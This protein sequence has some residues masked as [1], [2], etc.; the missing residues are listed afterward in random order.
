MK[1]TSILLLV[2]V[3][4]I[5]LI[6][7]ISR[8]FAEEK[9]KV[10]VLLK[11]QSTQYWEIITAGAE[12]GF[13]DF[14]IVGE[15][16]A[17][18]SATVE[19]QIELLERIL[20]NPPDVLIVSPIYPEPLYAAL[21][22]FV[23]QDIPVLFLD[24]DAPWEYKTSYVGTNNFDLGRKAG[25]LLGS[26][27]QPSDKVAIITGDEDSPVAGDRMRGAEV[28]LKEIGINVAASITQV[29]NDPKQVK[30]VLET[31]IGAH[32]DL[33]GLIATND[34]MALAALRVIQENGLN[35]PVIGADGI[36]EMVEL[37]EDGTLTGTVAQNPYDMGYLSVEA[38]SKVVRGEAIDPTIDS[39]VDII[40]KG[41]AKQ[42]LDFLRT[43]LD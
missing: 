9:P 24:T 42:R 10:T 43:L 34:L 3:I 11:D 19:E 41:N 29:S 5:V 33:K 6:S 18:E 8:P 15:V 28:R 13:R 1:R 26:H 17:P 12:K 30:D 16:V 35:I 27:L 2:C 7:F 39:G 22:P 14:G 32:P 31:I 36:I 38:A 21:E 4:A 23:Y 20:M 40:I 25:S 37:I